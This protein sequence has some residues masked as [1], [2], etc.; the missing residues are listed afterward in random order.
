MEW[1]NPRKAIAKWTEYFFLKSVKVDECIAV[2]SC[3]NLKNCED[4][5]KQQ[6]KS[7]KNFTDFIFNFKNVK[8][9]RKTK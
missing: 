6:K 5:D 3:Y 7:V 4:S 9:S 1:Y 2:L 8:A